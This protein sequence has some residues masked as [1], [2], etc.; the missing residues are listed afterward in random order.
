MSSVVYVGV[1]GQRIT[2]V[3]TVDYGQG[4]QGSSVLGQLISAVTTV[5]YGQDDQGS[6]M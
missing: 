6:R 4:D 3:T 5:D 2:T 1:L